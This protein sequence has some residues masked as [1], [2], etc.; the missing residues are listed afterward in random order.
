M[1]TSGMR[2]IL[3]RL[4]GFRKISAYHYLLEYIHPFY[5]GNGSLR[6]RSQRRKGK[7]REN[8]IKLN[9]KKPR[10]HCGYEVF[11]WWTIQES[12]LLPPVRQTGAL[13]K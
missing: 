4:Y 5:D 7:I 10:N 6:F 12:N 11:S 13:A 2:T 1:L 3:L 9:N 8:D